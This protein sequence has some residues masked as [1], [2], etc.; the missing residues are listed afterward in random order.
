MGKVIFCQLF[1]DSITSPENVGR[2]WG[3]SAGAAHI[4]RRC[5]NKRI[6]VTGDR[7]NCHV[8]QE[9]QDALMPFRYYYGSRF[10]LKERKYWLISARFFLAPPQKSKISY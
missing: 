7:V 9:T 4:L 2:R 6:Q 1:T 10:A 8:S 5:G 3:L